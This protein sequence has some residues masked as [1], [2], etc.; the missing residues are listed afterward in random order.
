MHPRIEAAHRAKQP[1]ARIHPAPWV[2]VVAAGM[3]QA[4]L[5]RGP[6]QAGALLDRQGIQ[7]HP[8]RHHG[9]PWRTQ[10]RHH[11]CGEASEGISKQGIAADQRGQLP[12]GRGQIP[13]LK[14]CQG[15]A[16]AGHG[17]TWPRCGDDIESLAGRLPVAE[18]ALHIAQVIVGGGIGRIALQDPAVIGG[19]RIPAAQVL[20]GGATVEMGIADRSTAAAS[21]PA[22]AAA[23]GKPGQ[24]WRGMDHPSGSPAAIPSWVTDRGRNPWGL[25]GVSLQPQGPQQFATAAAA[26]N[27]AVDQ[28]AQ[29]D[30][31]GRE[32]LN[33][34]PG[35][36][37]DQSQPDQKGR[38]ERQ[39]GL[40]PTGSRR[41]RIVEVGRPSDH[42]SCWPIQR[43][44]LKLSTRMPTSRAPSSARK[45]LL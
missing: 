28:Q 2:N 40:P 4:L 7:I 12:F 41:W 13:Q 16:G 34:V 27:P 19:C 32:R 30:G 42:G 9:S 36:A 24:A 11:T 22:L 21:P 44:R 15:S 10:L 25:S 38:R 5:F 6:T 23:A 33:P 1:S 3:H 26:G 37:V 20:L 31:Q 43:S 17:E 35:Q 8:K 29:A 18:A 45:V 39:Q 14:S